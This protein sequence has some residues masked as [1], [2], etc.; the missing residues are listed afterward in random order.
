MISS[1]LQN[2]IFTYA[3][4]NHSFENLKIVIP[5]QSQKIKSSIPQFKNNN[6]DTFVIINNLKTNG[7]QARE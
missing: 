7:E 1:S 6:Y 2:S 4:F 3:S 5:N